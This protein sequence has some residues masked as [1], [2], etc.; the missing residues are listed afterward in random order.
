MAQ[1]SITNFD[2][3]III[4]MQREVLTGNVLDIG[5][6]NNGI[7]YNIYKHYNEDASLEYVSCN[8]EQG[9]IEKNSY[10]T[11]IML[12]SLRNIWLKKRK[13]RFI[14]EI[15]EFLK[16]NG[17][18]HIWDIDK[19]YNK[20][21]KCRIQV[22]LPEDKTKIININELNI[23]KDTSKESVL[24]LIKYYFEVIDFKC[25]D[26]IYYIKAKKK[27]ST[28]DEASTSWNKF[29]VYTQQLSNKIFKGLHKGN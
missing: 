15:S 26:N 17:V 6:E 9:E 21:L 20:A 27:G 22:L 2:N 16:E 3:K 25:S 14:M 24:K 11:C 19:P 29:K 1:L 28:I 5:D 13:K 23:F 8:E 12:F 18:I 4:N 7:I 10:D